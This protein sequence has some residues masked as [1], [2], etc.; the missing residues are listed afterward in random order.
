MSR[1]WFVPHDV[2]TAVRGQLL[3]AQRTR[4]DTWTAC[5]RSGF[6]AHRLVGPTFAVRP[7]G[8]HWDGKQERV[9]SLMSA[10]LSTSRLATTSPLLACIGAAQTRKAFGPVS[11]A[12]LGAKE[13]AAGVVP[14]A[15][16][17]SRA[18]RLERVWVRTTFDR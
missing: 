15:R 6:R 14:A 13:R 16:D 18:P 3:E 12:R 11:T 7:R 1:V 10:E 5:I 4:P 2:G 9:E 17:V 8:N